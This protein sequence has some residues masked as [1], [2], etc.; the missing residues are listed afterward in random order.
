MGGLL[1]LA[2]SGVVVLAGLLGGATASV[3]FLTGGAT[4]TA[5]FATGTWSSATTRYLHNNPTPPVGNTTAQFNL[6]LDGTIPTAGTLFNYDTNC[7]SVA[8]RVIQRNTGAVTEATTCRYATWRTAAFA[9]AAVLSGT[10]SLE[11][12]A[13]KAGSTGG[14]NPTLR[15]WLRDFDPGTG[16]YVELGNASLAITTDSTSPFALYTFSI[17]VSA[18]V[19]TGHRIE[20]KLVALGGG[21]NVNIAYDTA[22]YPSTLTIP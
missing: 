18:T 12:S 1:V 17:P 9:A 21:R 19:A 15:A 3:A 13:R 7:D 16:T 11:I 2:L 22:A 6:A 5:S 8:G 14:T 20:L 4:T 10:A